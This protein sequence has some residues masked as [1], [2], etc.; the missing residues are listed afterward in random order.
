MKKIRRYILL[1]LIFITG[2]KFRP[3]DKQ[4]TETPY[5]ILTIET[6]NGFLHFNFYQTELPAISYVFGSNRSTNESA[7]LL[8]VTVTGLLSKSFPDVGNLSM[9]MYTSFFFRA[10]DRILS[11]IMLESFLDYI[12]DLKK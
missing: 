2:I 7:V 6:M 1:F 4:I 12:R 8:N 11:A 9:S 3:Y 5:R 10:S